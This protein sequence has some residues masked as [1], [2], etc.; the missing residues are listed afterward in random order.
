MAGDGND[1]EMVR[2]YFVQQ[3]EIL[4]K[5]GDIL[6]NRRIFD[7]LSDRFSIVEKSREDLEKAEG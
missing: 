2:Q 7:A 1:P 5:L 4:E 3:P 6:L